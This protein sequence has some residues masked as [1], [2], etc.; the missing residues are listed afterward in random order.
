MIVGKDIDEVLYKV[1]KKLKNAKEYSPRG[2]KTKELIQETLIIKNPK[3]CIITNPARKLSQIYLDK[4]LEWYLS[5]DK[6]IKMIAPYASMWTRIA[7]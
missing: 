2:Q 1:C 6:N 7:D 3:K 4:E 5:G